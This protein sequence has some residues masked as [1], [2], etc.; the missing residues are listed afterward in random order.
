[1]VRIEDKFLMPRERMSDILATLRAHLSPSEFTEGARY[2]TV[3]SL[4]LDSPDLVCL[5]DHVAGARERFKIRLRR[6]APDGVF[7]R[8]AAFLE[9]KR[10]VDAICTKERLA[11]DPA[12]IER[13]IAGAPLV[14]SP[15]LT[16]HNHQMSDRKIASR[17][18][19]LRELLEAHDA[20]PRV[21]VTYER[22]AFEGD[23]VRV[24]VDDDVRAV[25]RRAIDHRVAATLRREPAFAWAAS[26]SARFDPARMVI[27]EVK[28][29]AGRPA[30][31]D[32][33]MQAVGSGATNF[34]KYCFS[35]LD[36]IRRLA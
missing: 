5:R 12:S 25:F 23:G 32:E 17:L 15:A 35:M 34:S 10:K 16:R 9:V 14:P 29:L 33:S 30:W 11:L 22:R 19:S 21:T 28:H 27:V 13:L 31:L 6:Y 26:R 36:A 18:S 7:A 3:E 8:G 4:Y 20:R 1:M 24:T 2:T